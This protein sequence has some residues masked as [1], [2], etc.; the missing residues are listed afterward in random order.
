MVRLLIHPLFLLVAAI[1]IWAGAGLY[2]VVGLLAVLIHESAHAAVAY[3]FGIRAKRLTILP[4]GA[5]ISL[6]CAMLPKRVQAAIYLAGPMSNAAAAIVA[7]AALWAFPAL[8]N[9]LG[10][11]IVAN[12]LTCMLNLLPFY[13]LDGGKVVELF[14]S[15]AAKIS[16]WI[17]NVVFV[18]LLILGVVWV[19]FALVLFAC[20]MLFS[21]HTESRN[22]YAVTLTKLL[23]II[24]TNGKDRKN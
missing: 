15:R 10:L 17:S 4:F 24:H 21:I 11:F 9:V 22:E 8:F 18:G 23:E 20:C 7:G 5:A 2:L 1:C 12:C 3:R 16:F 19:H 14:G 13:P 6:D